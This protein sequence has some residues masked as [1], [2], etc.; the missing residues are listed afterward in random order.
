MKPVFA[1]L[2]IVIPFESVT[3]AK[4][5]AGT[6]HTRPRPDSLSAWPRPPKRRSNSSSR[7]SGLSLPG[8]VIT[9]DPEQLT[10]RAAELEQQMGAP[11][12]WDDQQA[13]AEISTEHSRITKRLERY[14]RLNRE[15]Q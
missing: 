8:S 5:R 9:F 1:A 12:F 3:G 14:E 2:N 4:P 11:G 15:Y 6:S 7:R 13:A 10:V